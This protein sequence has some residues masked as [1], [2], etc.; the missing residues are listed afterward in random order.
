MLYTMSE[1]PV[2]SY[3][4]VKTYFAASPQ[5]KEVLEIAKKYVKT[6]MDIYAR[7]IDIETK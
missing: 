3:D 1:M 4:E 7:I 2:Y 5:A 6:R